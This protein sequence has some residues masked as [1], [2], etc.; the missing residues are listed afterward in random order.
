M[1]VK[2]FWGYTFLVRPFFMRMNI[3]GRAMALGS[4]GAGGA[5]PPEKIRGCDFNEPQIGLKLWG[6]GSNIDVRIGSAP[7][8][9][10][11]SEGVRSSMGTPTLC[12]QN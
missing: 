11:L 9:F 4:G 1:N 5:A 12:L 10:C 3:L 8:F 2:S 6:N 7:F